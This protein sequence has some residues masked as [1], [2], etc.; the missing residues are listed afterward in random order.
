MNKKIVTFAS[1]VLSLSFLCAC[2]DNTSSSPDSSSY[3]SST[4]SSTD[5]SSS[6]VEETN[7][8]TYSKTGTVSFVSDYESDVFMSS[9]FEYIY[10]INENDV[11]G[12]Q[13]YIFPIN[14]AVPN[15]YVNSENQTISYGTE[16]TNLQS[17]A[18]MYKLPDQVEHKYSMDVYVPSFF[19]PAGVALEDEL[20]SL[21]EETITMTTIDGVTTM[22][23]ESVSGSETNL[24][25]FESGEYFSNTVDFTDIAA[26]VM[27]METVDFAGFDMSTLAI[28][29]DVLTDHLD[30]LESYNDLF[31][32]D[33]GVDLDGSA[34]TIDLF[35]AILEIISAGVDTSYDYDLTNGT[36]IVNMA[37]KDEALTQMQDSLT[38]YFGDNIY[39]E[40]EDLSFI[41]TFSAENLTVSDLGSDLSTLIS[42]GSLVLLGIE[43]DG[44]FLV[45]DLINDTTIPVDFVA[46]V[47]LNPDG[48]TGTELSSAEIKLSSEGKYL[49]WIDMD[50]DDNATMIETN[51]F[52][53]V[54]QKIDVYAPVAEEFNTFYQPIE[55]YIQSE[56]FDPLVSKIDI[57]E[58]G[59]TLVN[60]AAEAYETLS[61]EVKYMLSDEV[62]AS[63]IVAGY[64]EGRARLEQIPAL[65]TSSVATLDDILNLLYIDGVYVNQYVNFS[66]ALTE[67]GETEL[68]TELSNILESIF[69]ALETANEN[70]IAYALS[71]S[72]ETLATFVSSLEACISNDDLTGRLPDAVYDE[73]KDRCNM[74]IA[75]FISLREAYYVYFADLA[76]QIT[77]DID[78]ETLYTLISAEAFSV[79]RERYTGES[80]VLA[81][82]S[83][84]ETIDSVLSDKAR[85]L[86]SEATTAYGNS[87][88]LDEF[89]TNI[90]SVESDIARL[91]L[92]EMYLL[93]T[94][95]TYSSYVTTLISSYRFLLG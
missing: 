45:T 78:F 89:N 75:N 85:S 83:C 19:Y 64:N 3:S 92:I 13:S 55:G 68:L 70:G 6:S 37:L 44:S 72:E 54:Q 15:S 7:E 93:G 61:D 81:F 82:A 8:G 74:A 62:N 26:L 1:L 10:E 56:S 49:Y 35:T 73:Y 17:L 42:S 71:P 5:S 60:S 14:N 33:T 28:D 16:E 46:D 94:D 95:A 90:S 58:A 76:T 84:S 4:S 23:H 80:T 36:I 88:T 77:A 22:Y 52:D 87:S 32:F 9:E 11:L 63:S 86:L 40:A 18:N 66:A 57:S 2:S 91:D 27:F 65:Y 24:R 48:V 51:Q 20:S 29:W 50:F 12:N 39:V 31:S 41:I 79:L 43:S 21:P 69:V 47:G 34:E 30:N 59:R 67:M 38:E 25:G 53:D